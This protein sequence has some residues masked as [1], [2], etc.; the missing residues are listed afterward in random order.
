[1]VKSHTVTMP[2]LNRAMYRVNSE[3]EKRG[4]WTEKVQA[5]DV[6]LTPVGC[7]YGWQWYG[8][9]GDIVI[10]RWSIAQYFDYL[11]GNY[12][13]LADVLRHE[14][15]HAVADLHR[16]LVNSAEFGDAF[17]W[18][19]DSEEPAMQYD[20]YFHVTPYAATNVSEDFAEVF[21]L[22]FKHKGRI[23]ARHRTAPINAKW[24]FVRKLCAAIAKDKEKF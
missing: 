22:F 14:Y 3:F 21:S 23:P 18:E 4:I 13:P 9:G 15:G 10:P 2:R 12:V 16:D 24:K 17:G 11:M 5:V 8:L 19:H 6:Y 1:M 20:P 7:A